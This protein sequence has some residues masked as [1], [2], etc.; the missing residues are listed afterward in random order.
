M[1]RFKDIREYE[2]LHIVLW[3]LKDTC[4]VLMWEELGMIMIIP[5]LAAAFHITWIRRAIKTDLFHNLAICS[6]ITA[7]SIWMIGE[8]FFDDSL[9]PVAL[10]F[11]LMGLVSVSYYYLVVLPRT[12]KSV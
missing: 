1:L 2:N 10:V 8:F 11:F 9:R 7:N 3:L 6:W 12:R 5:T 4:W